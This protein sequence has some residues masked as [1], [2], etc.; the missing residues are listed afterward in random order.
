VYVSEVSVMVE[1]RSVSFT[2]SNI[3]ARWPTL[4]RS[5]RT[6]PMRGFRWT[7][8]WEAW[9]LSVVLRRFFAASHWSSH[10]SAARLT[11]RARPALRR[12]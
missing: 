1:C 4:S 3:S 11:R 10:S 12:R 7:R 6:C 2:E 9:P 8:M 5:R